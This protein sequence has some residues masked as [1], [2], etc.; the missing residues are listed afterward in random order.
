MGPH[1]T[2]DRRRCRLCKAEI[3][4][5]TFHEA[6]VAGRA[7]KM[8][9]LLVEEPKSTPSHDAAMHEL[10]G[11]HIEKLAKDIMLAPLAKP[12]M[13]N[14]NPTSWNSTYQYNWIQDSRIDSMTA[15]PIQVGDQVAAVLNQAPPPP[16]LIGGLT[17]E[18]CL[19]RY[20]RIQREDASIIRSHGVSGSWRFLPVE[21]SLAPD[22]L[23]AAKALWSQRLRAKV[24]ASAKPKLTVIVDDPDE[25]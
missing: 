21:L 12:G 14:L 4:G 15:I 17:A 18:Q 23:A 1:P 6:L 8:S 24:A 11:D 5:I 7:L 2:L 10:W 13:W 22:Q 25:P 19:E 3:C 16:K 20:E 9:D